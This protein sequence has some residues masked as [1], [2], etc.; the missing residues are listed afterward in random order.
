MVGATLREAPGI[1]FTWQLAFSYTRD[2]SCPN[3]V[4]D[5]W[6]GN[7]WHANLS[8]A[9]HKAKLSFLACPRRCWQSCYQLFRSPLVVLEDE[10]DQR[11]PWLPRDSHGNLPRQP[12]TATGQLIWSDIVLCYFMLWIWGDF[13][14]NNLKWNLK[15]LISSFDSDPED[16]LN[17]NNFLQR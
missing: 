6:E 1:P 5:V 7:S 4:R 11:I 2:G 14:S 10:R 3:A 8:Y 15:P 16:K 13:K 17:V 12:A 9:C